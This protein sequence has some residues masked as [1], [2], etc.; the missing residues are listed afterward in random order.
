MRRRLVLLLAGAGALLYV[1]R[2]RG[3]NRERVQLYFD[4]GSMVTLEQGSPDAERLLGIA[5]A[6]L[7]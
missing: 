7:S 1:A 4:D 3:A 2:R 6:A 5:R